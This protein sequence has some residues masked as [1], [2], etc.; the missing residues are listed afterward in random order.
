MKSMLNKL[1]ELTSD[2]KANK[3]L[4][5]IKWRFTMARQQMETNG[6]SSVGVIIFIITIIFILSMKMIILYLFMVALKFIFRSPV[7]LVLK[8]R[9]FSINLTEKMKRLG[10]RRREKKEKMKNAKQTNGTLFHSNIDPRSL[11]WYKCIL[12]LD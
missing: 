9:F 7:G 6:L 11:C 12:T 1:L 5:W 4:H 10:R 3:R 8:V 2:W